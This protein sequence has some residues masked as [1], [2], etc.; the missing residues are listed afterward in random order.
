MVQDGMLVALIYLMCLRG[1]MCLTFYTQ[2]GWRCI[3]FRGT[4]HLV[5]MLFCKGTRSCVVGNGL[6]LMD[7]DR[8]D[9]PTVVLDTQRDWR[10]SMNVSTGFG[11][12]K[13]IIKFIYSLWS[14][15]NP[16]FAFLPLRPCG[17]M[18]VIMSERT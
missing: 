3:R 4:F 12:S 15:K 17:H 5:H 16:L 1:L 13:R 2:R 11:Y 6:G 7:D 10:F 8:G 18:T 14:R 9:E